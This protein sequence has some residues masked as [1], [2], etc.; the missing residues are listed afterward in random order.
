[1]RL[2]WLTT[3][4]KATIKHWLD[5]VLV[6]CGVVTLA[7]LVSIV[8]WALSPAA[9]EWL[10]RIT[11]WVL[12][13][14]VVEELVRVSI[15]DNLVAFLRARW[16][17]LTLAVLATGE[18]FGHGP[19]L[20]WIGGLL[21]DVQARTI[22]LFY[23]AGTQLT[24]IALIGLRA[25]RGNRLLAS[26][27]LTPGQ[28]FMGSF[29]ALILVGM[30]LLKTPQATVQPLAWV[31]ALF[32]S[33]SAVCVTGLSTVDITEVLSVQGRFILLALIQVGGLG[34]VT[35]TY[36]FAHFMAGGMG[37]RTQ[38]Q[39]KDFFSEER[40]GQIG[41]VL[42]VVVSSTLAIEALGAIAIHHA[43]QGTGVADG[44]L[45]FFSI[46][47]SVSAFCNAGFSTL[48]AGLADARV[49]LHAPFLVTIMLLITLGGI[50][51]PVM[52]NLGE[53]A[54]NRLSRTIHR[55]HVVRVRVTTHTKLVL[56]V[57]GV[58]LGGGTL[59]FW[60]LEPKPMG[61]GEAWLTALFNSVTARTA[62][63]NTVS[64]SSLVPASLVAMMFLMYVGGSP[65]STAGGVKTTT[66]G[67]AILGLRRL[68]QGRA[69]MEFGGRRIEQN[70]VTRALI[71]LLLSLMWCTMVVGALAALYPKFS[72]MDLA[73]ET[74][75]ALST[76]GLSCG[77]VTDLG[78]PGK[79][80]L[81]LTMFV[82]RVGL[83]TC[84]MAF[85]REES[86]QPYRL[87]ESNLI[88]G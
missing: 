45:A 60:L 67:V 49:H 43:L 74:V 48:P 87:P 14:F 37:M 76:V 42:G 86:T 31:D 8:G 19:F 22:T 7:C 61:A 30:L 11:R 63:F 80:L 32:L 5:G 59:L 38:L 4:A 84:V 55:R 58:L 64:M 25:L 53:V 10:R 34:V 9:G 2:H 75:S 23:L 36:F 3:S 73:F 70:V 12:A 17:E 26:R 66:V 39:L 79:L 85:A 65:S 35:F 28:L 27:K 29:V 68:V 57:S 18:L 6:L 46:F 72:P 69:D 52:K 1:V 56:L 62:G 88:V 51:F 77:V 83:L 82:G 13:V 50:G 21:P 16:L 81:V 44:E 71:I 54:V 47:H 20:A 15:Q 40:L 24:V 41:T 33:T 78:A